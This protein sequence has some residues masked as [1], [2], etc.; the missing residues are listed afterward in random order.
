MC[1]AAFDPTNPN[2]DL[3]LAF[4]SRGDTLWGDGS[5]DDETFTENGVTYRGAAAVQH[6][7]NAAKATTQANEQQRQTLAQTAAY[8]TQF[9]AISADARG[10][11]QRYAQ[12]LGYNPY[13]LR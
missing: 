3:R 5:L 8:S 11:R 13:F 2:S 1:T 12:S 6:R 9:D 10:I 7:A 4:G